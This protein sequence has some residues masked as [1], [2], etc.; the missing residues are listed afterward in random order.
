MGCDIK[1]TYEQIEVQLDPGDAVV[2]YTDGISEAMNSVD[3]EWGE[4]ALLA[5]AGAARG[6]PATVL[7]Q[8]IIEAADRFV[9]GAPQYDD[10][11]VVALRAV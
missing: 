2:M 3:Q 9:A 6:M 11:T 5:T 10:M 7:I 4:D 8:R 1:H